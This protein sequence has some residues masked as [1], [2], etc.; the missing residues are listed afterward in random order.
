MQAAGTMQAHLEGS[1]A[2]ALQVGLAARA[3][4]TAADCAAAGLSAPADMLEGPFGW[5]ALYDPGDCGPQVVELGTR[6]RIREVSVKPWPC[7]R[8]SHGV[9]AAL[10]GRGDVQRIEAHVPP[11]VARLVGRPWRP[12]MGPSWA[13]LCLPFLVALMLRDGHIDPRRFTP[14]AAA[15]PALRR[16]GARLVI[17]EDGNPDPNALAPQRILLDGQAHA[18][19][20]MAGHPDAPRTPARMR[21][22]QALALSLAREPAGPFE[23]LPM[24]SGQPMPSG[25]S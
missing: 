8:A 15:D 5:L 14:E 12:D 9:L 20:A 13:R 2:L 7:G 3:A 21:A 10:E 23:P 19:N 25:A 1:P 22:K 18:I 17:H 6:W 16:L 11:L 24:L 4:V